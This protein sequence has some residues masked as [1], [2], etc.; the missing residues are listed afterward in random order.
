M[1]MKKIIPTKGKVILGRD[2]CIRVG[3]HVIGWWSK[4][5]VAGSSH[6][7]PSQYEGSIYYTAKLTN[8]D[9]LD[10][11]TMA[12]LRGAIIES[13]KDGIEPEEE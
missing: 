5:Y 11:W 6:Y 4:D 10:A 1:P 2:E 13:G 12:E 3:K 7:R 8:G 9:F